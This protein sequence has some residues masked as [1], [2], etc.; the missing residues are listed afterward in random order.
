MS[1]FNIGK[2]KASEIEQLVNIKKKID[3]LDKQKKALEE[4]EAELRQAIKEE[5]QANNI[6]TFDDGNVSI[7]IKDGYIRHDFDKA[8][9][10]AE[11]PEL[12]V[13]YLKDTNVNSTM[14]VKIKG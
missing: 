6:K 10:Q 2:S 1:F 5:M 8:K 14:I 7:T 9:F 11:N 4:K 12:Y 3:E 13:K